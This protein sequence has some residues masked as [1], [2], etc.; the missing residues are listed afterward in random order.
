MIR[1]RTSPVRG[2]GEPR[3]LLV[4]PDAVPPARPHLK[5]TADG[6][7]MREVLTYSRRGSRFTP[8]QQECWD[9]HHEAWVIP[10]D[11]VDGM[12]GQTRKLAASTLAVTE[13]FTEQKSPKGHFIIRYAPGHDAAIAELAGA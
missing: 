10:D 6:R 8:Y 12:V 11:A 7:R 5:L 1:V 2:I 4:V 3:S 9:A 13:T